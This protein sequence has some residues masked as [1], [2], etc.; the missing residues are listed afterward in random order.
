M[1]SGDGPIDGVS[2][3]FFLIWL[4]LVLVEACRILLTSCRTF[5][6][7]AWAQQLQHAAEFAS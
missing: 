2:T 7:G 5:H 3:F 4:H 1:A 6:F